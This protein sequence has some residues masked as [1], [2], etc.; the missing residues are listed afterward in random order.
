[1]SK[2][3]RHGRVAQSL[4][5]RTGLTAGLLIAV[6]TSSV[7]GQIRIQ[8]NAQ[9]FQVGPQLPTENVSPGTNLFFPNR[10]IAERIRRSQQLIERADY[11][12]GLPLLQ[13]AI[14][15]LDIS[16]DGFFNPNEN[17]TT[18]YLSLKAAARRL[19]E[20]LPREGL[21]S[22]ELQFGPKARQELNDA[23]AGHDLDLIASVE[24]KYFGTR[25]GFEAAD[26]LGN[27]YLDRS[28]PLAAALQF[29]RLRQSPLL[30]PNRRVALDVKTALAWLQAR[31]P[32]QA[33]ATMKTLITDAQGARIKVAGREFVISAT[34]ED[35]LNW[36]M[37][38]TELD[39]AVLERQTAADWTMF[40]GN[41]K[42]SST[43][44]EVSAVGIS[45]WRQRSLLMDI[46]Y[47]DEVKSEAVAQLESRLSQLSQGAFKK[48]IKVPAAHPLVIGDTVVFRTL[49]TLK[50]VNA[51]TGQIL[52]EAVD[53]DPALERLLDRFGEGGGGT[54]PSVLGVQADIDLFLTQRA[55]K[56]ATAG[57]ISSNGKQVY[58]VDDLPFGPVISTQRRAI[59]MAISPARFNTIKAYNVDGGRLVWRIGGPGTPD[60]DGPLAGHFFLGAPLPIGGQLY[61]LAEVKE[62]IRLICLAPIKATGDNH[63]WNVEVVWS[64]LLAAPYRDFAGAAT[65]PLSGIT[66]SYSQ[67]VLIC[68]TSA[69]ATVGF[70]LAGRQL[71]WGYQ[72]QTR[73]SR[74]GLPA[75]L[76]MAIRAQQMQMS[77]SVV[78]DE[79]RGRW[80]DSVPTVAG[81][82]VLLTPRDSAELH[83]VDL[84]TGRMNWKRPRGQSLFVAAIH[85]NLVVLAGHS[86]IEAIR[87]SDGQT[88]WSSG[89]DI[90]KP[91]GRGLHVKS[92]YH[93]PLESGEI[94]TI[95]LTNG[96]LL[97]RSQTRSQHVPG[98]LI[99]AGDRI[100][101]QNVT[102]LVG[103][104]PLNDIQ[105][106]LKATLS[107]SSSD[108]AALALRGE[109][110]LS[111]GDEFGGLNDLRE[112]L[113]QLALMTPP[114]EPESDDSE[115]DSDTPASDDSKPQDS[116]E[117]GEDG[118][119]DDP[120]EDD[121]ADEPKEPSAKS[122]SAEQSS[123][124]PTIAPRPG[125]IAE[126]IRR[127][128][129]VARRAAVEA[130][131]TTA[132]QEEDTE[133]EPETQTSS[134]PKSLTKRVRALLRESLLEGLRVDF[135]KYQA[136]INEVK[137]LLDSE[138]D[139]FRFRQIMADGLLAEG[140]FDEAFES[141]LELA[142]MSVQNHMVRPTFD[143][144]VRIDRWIAQR[145]E[146]LWKNAD[147]A[148]RQRMEARIAEILE[149]AKEEPV[150][151]PLRGYIEAFPGS[152][153]SVE[154][155][156]ELARLLAK[157]GQFS[158][159]ARHLTVIAEGPRDQ[160]AIEASINLTQYA[161]LNGDRDVA[162]YVLSNIEA[163][164][165][166]STDVDGEP[167]GQTLDAF[168]QTLDPNE[169]ES[170]EWPTGAMQVQVRP[171]VLPLT[172]TTPI[173]VQG[174]RGPFTDW[175]FRLNTSR[176]GLVAVDGRGAMR[177]QFPFE[178]AGSR[179]QHAMQGNSVRIAGNLIVLQLG[180][181]FIVLDQ[182][183]RGD[184]PRMLWRGTLSEQTSRNQRQ[185]AVQRVFVQGGVGQVV[186]SS[187]GGPV[188]SLGPVS[189]STIVYQLGESLI[190]AEATTGETLWRLEMIP[191]GSRLFGTTETVCVH[192]PG[193]SSVLVL[194]GTDGALV[195]T[196]SLPDHDRVHQLADSYLLLQSDRNGKTS[197]KVMDVVGGEIVS[198]TGLDRKSVFSVVGGDKIALLD[199]TGQFQM[200]E[201]RSGKKVA[202]LKFPE[203]P[204]L[205]AMYVRESRRQF[206][207]AVNE[208]QQGNLNA[209]FVS[210]SS[211]KTPINGPL[212]SINRSTGELEWTARITD[213]TVDF[214]Q[215]RE[216]PILV[217]TARRIQYI[218][219]G[220]P[221][222]QSRYG[223]QIIDLRDGTTV[224]ER[225]GPVSME[226]YQ[227]NP[228]SNAGSIRV[229]FNKE[230]AAVSF[231]K[232]D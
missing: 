132:A 99:A 133:E 179:Y 208:Q 106:E 119:T 60:Q 185:A 75:G 102:E 207:V 229:D 91:S 158:E 80:I 66:P 197:W 48:L 204:N 226:P 15:T 107:E 65:R 114:E 193:S 186:V 214:E 182:L 145:A 9:I 117:S 12:R 43:V 50:A 100:V 38:A 121:A 20:T 83:C 184:S 232:T 143:R 156:L 142:G 57:Q 127:D 26:R 22:Y 42:R 140:R 8:G 90:G 69:G 202:G 71:L 56:D 61:V 58:L 192:P 183:N 167:L 137:E 135:A 84:K 101:S 219:P 28:N 88:E 5:A 222:L 7:S 203:S 35:P 59:P 79:D 171:R 216:M 11:T 18:H 217:F 27:I 187:N 82:R 181:Y 33:R 54:P 189:Q 113:K 97:N 148:T 223:A 230:T 131:R 163:R 138:D 31:M 146:P 166:D 109:L 67:G 45:D 191:R 73:E 111:L 115:P 76:P 44:Q 225:S 168:R 64:Q 177:W 104:R 212:Y 105:S 85:E 190:A 24:R 2:R 19:I 129:S 74:G 159:A 87:L 16:E 94:A 120:E 41:S 1:M 116:D 72:Y 210:Q 150:D 29:Q 178:L 157:T 175:T 47:D 209:R 21:K 40:R 224:F 98:N 110:R 118:S 122:G 147:S 155:R 169:K 23:V 220:Q 14:D 201:I 86:H 153:A 108:A 154:A 112:A 160:L 188:G 39:P 49:G 77:G 3:F 165:P 63:R 95:D 173:S 162:R 13:S 221:N 36:L 206:I 196:V 68:P 46:Y 10:A 6:L 4:T 194:N 62:E 170:V 53:A 37:E 180:T 134:A 205:L 218:R 227:I 200:I 103:F 25:A 96:R 172:Y 198:E 176:Q 32:Q 211:G 128:L 195:K 125:S 136:R 89:A 231:S 52:W 141:L 139:Q 30:P 144:Q 151:G 126:Q 92:R 161:I 199:N 152:N 55:W 17:D 149:R 130:Q 81:N 215:P 70:D 51:K 174:G 164:W 93:L 78:T 123:T 124:K 228:G 34:G 213:Q